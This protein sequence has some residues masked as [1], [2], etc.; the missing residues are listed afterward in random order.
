MSGGTSFLV[1]YDISMS[2]RRLAR[3]RRRLA[4]VATPLQQSVFLGHFTAAERR[5][6]IGMLA[7]SIDPAAD[8]VRIYPVPN[9]PAILMLGRGALPEGIHASL[10]EI[11][12]SSRHG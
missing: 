10:P 2:Q 5:T 1:C 3:V 9:R 4:R 6:V 11:A 7:R 8:D 12:S